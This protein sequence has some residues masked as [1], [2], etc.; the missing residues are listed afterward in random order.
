M[1]LC[2]NQYVSKNQDAAADPHGNG[3][4]WIENRHCWNANGQIASNSVAAHDRCS[5]KRVPITLGCLLGRTLHAKAV[6][7]GRAQ[8]HRTR[9]ARSARDALRAAL[10]GRYTQWQVQPAVVP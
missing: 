10:C 9:S 7:S 6:V 4:G 2:E 3:N 5:T 1:V 8:T